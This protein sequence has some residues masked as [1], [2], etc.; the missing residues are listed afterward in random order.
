MHYFRIVQVIR[1]AECLQ[2]RIKDV[3]FQRREIMI[4][5]GKGGKD[6]VTMLP[7][8]LVGLLTGQINFP[9]KF[10][11][12]PGLITETASRCPHALE[13][14]SPKAGVPWGWF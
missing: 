11:K 3:D 4:W 14:K 9:K 10:M 6:R 8:S 2:L 12:L 1:L 13:L 7:L 5:E